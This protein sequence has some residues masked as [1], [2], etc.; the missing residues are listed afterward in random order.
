MF[1]EKESWADEIGNRIEAARVVGHWG[2]KLLKERIELL[3]QD[4][5]KF[6]LWKWG[7]DTE[8]KQNPIMVYVCMYNVISENRFTVAQPTQLSIVAATN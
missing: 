6:I 3:H 4:L 1:I 7:M 8:E 2:I 5:A